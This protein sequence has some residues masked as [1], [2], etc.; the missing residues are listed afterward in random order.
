MLRSYTCKCG[1]NATIVEEHKV[2]D[3]Y[4]CASCYLK[5]QKMSDVK[6]IKKGQPPKR[7]PS[8]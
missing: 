5:I 2:Q 1:K 3:K 4:W 6:K 7:L 8:F